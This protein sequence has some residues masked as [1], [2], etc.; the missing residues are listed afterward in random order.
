MNFSFLPSPDRD[1]EAPADLERRRTGRG[2]SPDLGSQP[3]SDEAIVRGLRRGNSEAATWLYGRV[4][5]VVT[6]ALLQ[7]LGTGDRDHE[8][9][10]Q[11][12][13]ERVVVTVMNGKYEAR[14]SLATWASVVTTRL[15]IDTLR[16]RRTERRIFHEGDDDGSRVPDSRSMGPESRVDLERKMRALRSA[17]GKV[18]PEKAETVILFEVLGHGLTEVA[19]FTGVSVSAAQT[20]LVRGRAELRDLIASELERRP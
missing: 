14:C 5:H 17:L 20:R 6:S 19:Q 2:S 10:A 4:E 1:A 18:S 9:L 15:A 8:D 11:V 3:P 13:L 16:R 7:V 12:A